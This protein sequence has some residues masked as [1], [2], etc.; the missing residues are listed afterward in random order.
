MDNAET[1]PSKLFLLNN[2]DPKRKPIDSQNKVKDGSSDQ[3]DKKKLAEDKGQETNNDLDVKSKN[4]LSES[5]LQVRIPGT[6][7]G[8]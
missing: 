4:D 2:K 8:A 7:L 3:A 5:D 6:F 1:S